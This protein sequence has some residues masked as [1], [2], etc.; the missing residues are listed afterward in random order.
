LPNSSRFSVLLPAWLLYETAMLNLVA[1]LIWNAK[2]LEGLVLRSSG[3]REVTGVRQE[4]ARF[5]DAVDFVFERFLFLLGSR[6]SVSSLFLYVAIS[7]S[8]D[9]LLEQHQGGGQLAE[10]EPS[11]P[12]RKLQL[13]ET[14]T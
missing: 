2:D 4:L 8:V 5:D 7:I 13:V 12:D 3:E 10:M 9:S 11:P 1:N 14:V 6:P